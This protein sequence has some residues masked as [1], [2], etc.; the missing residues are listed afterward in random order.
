MTF[1]QCVCVCVYDLF[2][3]IQSSEHII[4]YYHQIGMCVCVYIYNVVEITAV[5]HSQCSY[6]VL[7]TLPRSINKHHFMTLDKTFKCHSLQYADL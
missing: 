4:C 6:E 1:I 5:L 7:C 3:C 2:I